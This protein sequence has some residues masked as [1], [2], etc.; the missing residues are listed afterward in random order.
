MVTNKVINSIYRK[1][2]KRPGSPDQLDIALLFQENM[3]QHGL[4]IDDNKLVVSS[5]EP[6]SPFHTI[7]LSRVHAIL[8]FENVVAIVLHSSIIFFNKKDQQVHIH[9]KMDQPSLMDRIKMRI[10]RQ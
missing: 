2:K 1:Y 5:V 8:E 9:V 7:D 4:Y 3:D 6:S 10:A